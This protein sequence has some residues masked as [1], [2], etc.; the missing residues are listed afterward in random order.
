MST[1]LLLEPCTRRGQKNRRRQKFEDRI[2]L[3]RGRTRSGLAR[4]NIV[5]SAVFEARPAEVF[6]TFVV[7]AFQH[8]F[9]R[10]KR[11]SHGSHK[12]RVGFL[13]ENLPNFPGWIDARRGRQPQALARLRIRAG[14]KSCF[15]TSVVRAREPTF[16][17]DSSTYCTQP[18]SFQK[19]LILLHRKTAQQFLFNY[20]AYQFRTKKQFCILVAKLLFAW[21]FFGQFLALGSFWA[22]FAFGFGANL[23]VALF[24]EAKTAQNCMPESSFAFCVAVF[25][26]F[27]CLANQKLLLLCEKAKAIFALSISG[28]FLL[29]VGKLFARQFSSKSNFGQFLLLVGKIFT[30]QF[31]GKSNF[32]FC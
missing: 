5:A 9:C 22:V 21:Q 23:E 7:F 32:C 3:A 16:S 15:M 31:L 6:V 26:Q 11:R 4:R 2:V 27:C 24:R 25:G 28:Q 30:R 10:A 29:L 14:G 8:G 17:E 19:K 1:S 20:F 13:P 12:I 18:W